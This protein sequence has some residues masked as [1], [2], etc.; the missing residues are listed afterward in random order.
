MCGRARQCLSSSDVI[1]G[2]KTYLSLIK[3]LI[4]EEQQ[5]VSSGM[6]RE[7]ERCEKAIALAERGL[8]VSLVSSG[9]P[10]VYG[11]AGILYQLLE[12]KDSDIP[13]E[14][15]PGITAASAAAASLGA[16]LMHDFACISL[17]DLLTPWSTILKRVEY[18][19]RGDFVIALYNPKS[20]KRVKHIEEV[21]ELLLNILSPDTPVG[22]V[23]NAKRGQEE[24]IIT[25]LKDFT[26]HTIDMFTTVI[27][28]NSQSYVRDGKFIT[29]RGYQL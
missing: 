8:R 25:N 11:M 19:A 3:H 18:A 12:Q 9:D 24:V 27:I 1:V 29:P 15:V 14:V 20:K 4:G 16:P 22:I 28:G 13:V 6:T 2:Y 7:V 21:R 23:R 5:V 26:S 10:G 17:S